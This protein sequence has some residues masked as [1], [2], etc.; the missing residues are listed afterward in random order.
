MLASKKVA[1]AASFVS[2]GGVKKDS[3][4][5]VAG[6]TR[7]DEAAISAS[8]VSNSNAAVKQRLVPVPT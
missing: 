3:A 7:S 2:G 1:S 8:E 6:V 4:V 5:I